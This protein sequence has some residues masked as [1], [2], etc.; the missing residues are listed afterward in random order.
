MVVDRFSKYAHFAA[1][2]TRFDTLRV[3]HLFVNTV[4]HHHG[5]PKT[6]VSDRG[7]VFLNA[8]WEEI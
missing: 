4:V 8:V 7:S 5:F 3:A 1:L 2:P 6:L